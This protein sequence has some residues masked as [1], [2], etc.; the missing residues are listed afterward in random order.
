[1]FK[2]AWYFVILFHLSSFA[3]SPTQEQDLA[4]LAT[5]KIKI[6]TL[7]EKSMN[8]IGSGRQLIFEVVTNSCLPLAGEI[9]GKPPKRT[10]VVIRGIATMDLKKYPTECEEKSFLFRWDPA[11]N[12]NEKQSKMKI[13]FLSESG[14][15]YRASF[16]AF[17]SIG[18]IGPG[19]TPTSIIDYENIKILP[20]N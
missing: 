9:T 13:D 20:V 15:G 8:A 4:I 18:E 17:R 1:M 19:S 14:K 6:V 16:N 7:K 10:I 11:L 5:V 2:A 3:S 12:D